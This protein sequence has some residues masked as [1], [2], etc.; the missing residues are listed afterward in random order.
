MDSRAR[1]RNTLYFIALA[2]LLAVIYASY[3]TLGMAGSPPEK[4]LSELLTA[5]DQKQVARATLNARWGPGRLVGPRWGSVPQ[6]LSGWVSAGRQTSPGAG[7]DHRDPA[8]VD[9]SLADG[10]AAEHPALRRDRRVHGVPAENREAH[11]APRWAELT[12]ELN[13][14]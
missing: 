9:E 1:R 3:R 10:A 4:S 12:F 14:R 6:L 7:I 11:R 2:G 8:I 13:K 5:L